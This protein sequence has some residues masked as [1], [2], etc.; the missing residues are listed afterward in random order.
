MFQQH[1][2]NKL[3]AVLLDLKPDESAAQEYALY[4]QTVRRLSETFQIDNPNF[5][6]D[7]WCAAC[8]VSGG[9]VDYDR[10]MSAVGEQRDELVCAIQAMLNAAERGNDSDHDALAVIRMEG[11]DVLRSIGCA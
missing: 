4:Y 11:A 9:T 10:V 3:A 6:H 8:G 1:H 7:K 2:F 5:K